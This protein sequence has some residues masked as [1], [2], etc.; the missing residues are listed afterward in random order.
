MDFHTWIEEL[1]PFYEPAPQNQINR[2]RLPN[3]IGLYTSWAGEG[4]GRDPAGAW[5]EAKEDLL[6][7]IN[8]FKFLDVVE[9]PDDGYNKMLPGPRYLQSSN[10]KDQGPDVDYKFIFVI[11]SWGEGWTKKKALENAIKTA[12]QKCIQEKPDV[13]SVFNI[14]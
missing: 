10:F 9:H 1:D 8:S 5:A 12:Y 7:N 4:I 13:F 3:P 14:H 2:G 11:K 6:R